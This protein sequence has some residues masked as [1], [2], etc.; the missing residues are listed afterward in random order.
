MNVFSRL[1]LAV[2]VMLFAHDGQ[3][4]WAD[5]ELPSIN[6]LLKR[7][8]RR[9][10]RDSH[11]LQTPFKINIIERKLLDTSTRQNKESYI[12]HTTISTD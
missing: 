10:G 11:D 3:L 7:L 4:Y 5:P 9:R 6:R 12:H 1:Q 8:K 2:I